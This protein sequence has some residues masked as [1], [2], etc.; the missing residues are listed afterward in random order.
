MDIA[1]GKYLFHF[2]LY[3]SWPYAQIMRLMQKNKTV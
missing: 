2:W 3:I 1:H